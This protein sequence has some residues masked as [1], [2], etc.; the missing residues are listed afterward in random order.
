MEPRSSLNESGKN[1][2]NS[3]SE[4][5]PIS[6]ILIQSA[7][8]FKHSRQKIDLFHWFSF[9]LLPTLN[10]HVGFGQLWARAQR[11]TTKNG[12]QC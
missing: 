7:S 4:N 5:W 6:L 9:S 8:Y 3:I 10:I 12:G 1:I 11:F 2:K